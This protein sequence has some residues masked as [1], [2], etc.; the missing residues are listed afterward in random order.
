MVGRER[1]EREKGGR[2]EE[3]EGE[4]GAEGRGKM[5]GSSIIIYTAAVQQVWVN[6]TSSHHRVYRLHML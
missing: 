5:Y 2:G 3:R 4:E 6:T 1:E